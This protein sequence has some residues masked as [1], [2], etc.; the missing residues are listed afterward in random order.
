MT[1]IPH[2]YTWIL[3]GLSLW[4]A[5]LR[6]RINS[7]R[8]E[9]LCESSVSYT[10]PRLFRLNRRLTRLRERFQGLE[11]TYIRLQAAAFLALED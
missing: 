3:L 7:R 6:I 8:M 10:S 4:A 1:K 2:W 11:L 5:G 9:R